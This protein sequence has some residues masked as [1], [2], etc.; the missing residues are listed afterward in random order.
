MRTAVLNA[1]CLKET[2]PPPLSTLRLLHNG[3]VKQGN[4]HWHLKIWS[5]GSLHGEIIGPQS[6]FTCIQSIKA[7]LDFAEIAG[8]FAQAERLCSHFPE[9]PLLPDDVMIE[10]TESDRRC[11]ISQA[12]QSEE[13][14]AAFF[15]A[16]QKILQP[17]L[18]ER[19]A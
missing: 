4:P 1:P 12:E 15:I 19:P 18:S 2:E 5:D 14:T 13:F 7:Q 9:R 8:L 17:Y 10:L 6:N 11:A 16:L 3:H